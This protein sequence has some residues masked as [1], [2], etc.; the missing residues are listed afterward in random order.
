Q[1]C[2][3]FARFSNLGI[4][5]RLMDSN[6]ILTLLSVG[7]KKPYFLDIRPSGKLNSM[8]PLRTGLLSFGLVSIPV[9]LHAPLKTTA[10]RLICCTQSAALAF[11]TATI[12]RYVMWRLSGTIEFAA[13]SS[14]TTST[15][16]L[17]RAELE[18]LETESSNNIELKEFILKTAVQLL[19]MI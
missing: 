19:V 3:F 17:P 15:S 6:P 14:P 5:L 12:A 8:P 18:S 9:Q 11:K 1:L 4:T 13:M 10:S 2:H 16:S 7:R